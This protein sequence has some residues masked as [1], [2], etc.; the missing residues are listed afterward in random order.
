MICQ[1]CKAV[2]DHAKQGDMVVK[3]RVAGQGSLS[4][5]FCL[6]CADKLILSG[7]FE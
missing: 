4:M 5:V 1:R 6:K 3:V 7:G 2:I